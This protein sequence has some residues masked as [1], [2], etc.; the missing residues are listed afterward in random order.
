MTKEIKETKVYDEKDYLTFSLLFLLDE[1][2]DNAY[3]YG[4]N[5]EV[6]SYKENLHLLERLYYLK[7]KED[8]KKDKDEYEDLLK[9]IDN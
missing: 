9:E 1:E 6:D 7:N 4:E 5:E 3:F 2:I 8:S